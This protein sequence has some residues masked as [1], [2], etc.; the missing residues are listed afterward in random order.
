MDIAPEH[1]LAA[2]AVPGGAGVDDRAGFHGDLGGL[3]DAVAALPVAADQHGSSALLALGLYPRG[4]AEGDVIAF[5]QDTPSLMGDGAGT[6]VRHQAAAVLDHASAQGADRLG[7]QD[8]L[9]ISRLD[10]LLVLDQRR[11]VAGGDHDA[12]KLVLAVEI[13]GD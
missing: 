5:Q 12:G 9:A 13:E 8:D 2:V 4:A 6:G 10:G 7:A 11:D 1:D 3:V